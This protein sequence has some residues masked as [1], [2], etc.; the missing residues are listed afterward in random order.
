M[1]R[2]DQGFT[3]TELLV[4]IALSSVVILL[5]IQLLTTT[6][7][8]Y[9]LQREINIMHSNGQFAL[10]E[11]RQAIQA[12]DTWSCAGAPDNVAADLAGA[13][14][15]STP[16]ID[17]TEASPP[18]SDTLE[19]QTG[20]RRQTTQL[21]AA[22]DNGD[23]QVNLDDPSLFA[24]ELALVA[25]CEHGDVVELG[26]GS[27]NPRAIKNGALSHPDGGYDINATVTRAQRVEFSVDNGDCLQRTDVADNTAQTLLCD[28]DQLHFR[29]GVDTDNDGAVNQYVDAS[30]VGSWGNVLA[31][32]T[33]IVMRSSSDVDSTQSEYTVFGSDYTAN[34][35]RARRTFSTT[36]PIRSRV[37]RGG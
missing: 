4:A 25:D 10:R 26:G 32:Q 37:Y 9:Y 1:V 34:D 6:T 30:S 15:G 3:M 14:I 28:V 16:T 19:I 22:A 33:A 20:S 36:T 24:G 5:I 8:S 17:G 7:S 35:E 2:T 23:G 29:Y 27:N 12:A 31:V 21:S 13:S 11:L 18:N